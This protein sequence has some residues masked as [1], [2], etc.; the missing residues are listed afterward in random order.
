MNMQAAI[1]HALSEFPR[2]NV[3][4]F[5]NGEYY[6]LTNIIEGAEAE[7]HFKLSPKDCLR[8]QE[9]DID[10]LV[11][12]HTNGLDHPTKMD[13]ECQAEMEKPWFVIVLQEG[14]V[15]KEVFE[16][17]KHL[18][19]EPYVNRKFR[20][21]VNDCVTLVSEWL[22][23]EM[24]VPMH[25]PPDEFGW[26]HK[27]EN[28]IIEGLIDQKFVKVKEKD[29]QRGDVILMKIG[30]HVVNHLGVYLGRGMM[31]HHPALKPS[32][33]SSVEIWRGCVDGYMRYAG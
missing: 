30:S 9:L 17:G 32:R 19:A 24:G 25:R 13:L 20:Y 15:L 22:K 27:G 16:F 7:E 28:L 8:L 18:P 5:K 3:G 21:G 14:K 1:E 33:E 29:T 10:A 11:H 31:L 2:E 4:Y 23:R 12:S 26:W 6:S